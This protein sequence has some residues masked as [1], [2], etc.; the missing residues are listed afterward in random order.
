MNRYHAEKAKRVH[1]TVTA[2]NKIHKGNSLAM[3]RTQ[4]KQP[5]ICSKPKPILKSMVIE[6]Q[7]S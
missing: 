3:Q 7:S 2:V 1:L 5:I 6:V 4:L